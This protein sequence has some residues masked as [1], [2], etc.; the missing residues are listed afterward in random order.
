M[1]LQWICE[2]EELPSQWLAGAWSRQN[3]LG[4]VL[5]VCLQPGFASAWWWVYHDMNCIASGGNKEQETTTGAPRAHLS[6]CLSPGHV[7]FTCSSTEEP[8]PNLCWS[9]AC[10]FTGA[11]RAQPQGSGGWGCPP[12]SHVM[13]EEATNLRPLSCWRKPI[14][15]A[16][17]LSKSFSTFWTSNAKD[18]FESIQAFCTPLGKV[19]VLPKMMGSEMWESL[20]PE[21]RNDQSCLRL[22]P[23]LHAGPQDCACASF[24]TVHS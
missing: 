21:I 2:A 4:D 17:K 15:S 23:H 1:I 10:T 22:F 14:S 9:S 16:K 12:P 18:R 3:V 8:F 7:S 20:A 24:V 6:P 5:S 11:Q 13:Q 19:S